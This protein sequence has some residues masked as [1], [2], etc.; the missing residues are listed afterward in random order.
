MKKIISIIIILSMILICCGGSIRVNNVK[1][2]TYG[3]LN[4][5]D[6]R[7]EFIEYKPIW[8]NIALGAAFFWTY[9]APIYFYG[10]DMM[11]PVGVKDQEKLEALTMQD[12]CE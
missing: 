8:G 6:E 7:E 5:A 10:F 11:E 2:R 9:F 1:Y 4:R 3:V 12:V